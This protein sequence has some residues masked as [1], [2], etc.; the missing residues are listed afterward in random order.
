[1]W[2]AYAMLGVQIRLNM[3]YVLKLSSTLG[4]HPGTLGLFYEELGGFVRWMG[5]PDSVSIT[6]KLI[7]LIFLD[8][9]VEKRRRWGVC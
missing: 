5:K 1:M 9:Y 2:E 6:S 3:F 8:S 7:F 4:G